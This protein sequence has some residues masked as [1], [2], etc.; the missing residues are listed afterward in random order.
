MKY[1]KELK[2]LAHN[3]RMGVQYCE[4][5]P[6]VFV[7]EDIWSPV[8]SYGH[9]NNGGEFWFWNHYGSSANDATLEELHWVVTEIFGMTV[10]EFTDKYKPINQ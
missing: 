7:Q 3:L 10:K 2:E 8:L 4:L 5:L 9:G 6:K 1:G